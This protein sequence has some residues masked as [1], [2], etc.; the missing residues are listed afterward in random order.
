MTI[1][2]N[3]TDEQLPQA[4]EAALSVW[5]DMNLEGNHPFTYEELEIFSF[6]KDDQ[7]KVTLKETSSWDL[8]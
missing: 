2:P 1:H 5:H 4:I 6:D 7:N 8:V 3:L